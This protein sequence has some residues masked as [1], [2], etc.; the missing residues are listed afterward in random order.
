M[1]RK[2]IIGGILFSISMLAIVLLQFWTLGQLRDETAALRSISNDRLSLSVRINAYQDDGFARTM[3]LVSTASPS[4]RQHLLD[5]IDDLSTQTDTAIKA[6]AENL[7]EKSKHGRVV[8]LIADRQRYLKIRNQLIEL[9]KNDHYPEALALAQTTFRQSY[10]TYS[11]TVDELL[12][13][14]SQSVSTHAA[15]V[16]KFCSIIV[17]LVPAIGLIGVFIGFIVP[18]FGSTLMGNSVYEPNLVKYG[19]PE[20]DRH[21]NLTR[22]VGWILLAFVILFG[23]G[24]AT[25]CFLN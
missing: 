5:E 24:V 23:L 13:A 10:A 20:T 11:H 19:G 21:T 2:I 7:C 8:T 4:D 14:D 17:F 25:R 6:Y 12:I 18:V 22:W 1:G 16:N 3:E 15:R 9:V